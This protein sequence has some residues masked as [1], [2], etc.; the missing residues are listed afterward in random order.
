MTARGERT[1]DV[2]SD[3]EHTVEVKVVETK[4]L[5]AV[6]ESSRDVG[7]LVLGIPELRD[8]KKVLAMD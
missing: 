5:E 4:L 6:I 1:S 7:G 3:A 8:E 2:V